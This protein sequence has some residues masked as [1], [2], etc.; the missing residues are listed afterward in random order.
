MNTSNPSWETSFKIFEFFCSFQN[1]RYFNANPIKFDTIWK[2]LW[3]EY[4]IRWG[5]LKSIAKFNVQFLTFFLTFLV[6]KNHYYSYR[7]KKQFYG[8]H[9]SFILDC[10]YIMYMYISIEHT[11]KQ[12]FW[13]YF[14]SSSHVIV[15]LWKAT[16]I[17]KTKTLKHLPLSLPA[18]LT[19]CVFVPLKLICIV[20]F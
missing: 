18:S 5:P 15:L 13:I 20:F 16:T 14:F 8:F 10:M 3:V 1:F 6:W 9:L 12:Y 2:K 4:T 17:T 11:F 19:V 7:R